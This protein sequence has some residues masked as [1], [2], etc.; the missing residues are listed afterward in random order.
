MFQESQINLLKKLLETNSPSGNEK[1]AINF[2]KSVLQD[3]CPIETDAMGNMYMHAVNNTGLKVMITAHIDEVGFQVTHIDR[4]GFVYFR[5]VAGIDR[6]TIPGNRVVA[7]T[8]HGEIYGVIGKKSPHVIDG[9]DIDKVP[10]GKDLWLDF[11][12]ESDVD[13]KSVIE[14]GDYITL[15][16]SPLIS[17][18]GQRII[19]KALDNK[20]G[21]FILVEVIKELSKHKD[22]PI[23]ITG[24]ATVQEE[25]GCRGCEAAVN[26]I[27]PDIAFCLDVGISTDIPNMSIQR[28]GTFSLGNGVGIVHN[29]DNNSRL[30]DL[31]VQTAEK[32][33]IPYQHTI[34][35]LPTGGTEA[36]IIQKSCNT[37]ATANISI[38]NRYMHSFVEMCDLRDIENAISLLVSS[39]IEL[40]NKN[41]NSFDLL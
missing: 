36:S 14:C 40:K 39:I 27:R 37:V 35:Y 6:Q 1:Q 30:T 9:K 20:V 29:A 7:L 33:H 25:L 18:N 21:V 17:H 4:D 31:L 26:R 32:Q 12:F 16:S 15:S 13:A 11:G 34:G 24:V 10:Y 2:L 22:L 28:F 38:P 19:S 3:Y 23:S 8:K 41:N 5:N